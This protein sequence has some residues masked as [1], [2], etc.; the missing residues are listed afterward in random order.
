M[1]NTK[2][3]IIK[4]GLYFLGSTC[5]VLSLLSGQARAS[6]NFEA[7]VNNPNL[8]QPIFNDNFRGSHLNTHIWRVETDDS[9]GGC[10]EALQAYN[11]QQVKVDNGLQLIT[12]PQ[13]W[14]QP[15]GYKGVLEGEGCSGASPT[16]RVARPYVGGRI[17]PMERSISILLSRDGST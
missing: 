8:W 6:T 4:A 9:T 14:V 17:V 1:K 7:T 10:N 13:W 11:G 2:Y 5:L 12:K 3:E 16:Q 15:M